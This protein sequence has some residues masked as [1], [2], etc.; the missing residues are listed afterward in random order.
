MAVQPGSFNILNHIRFS[1]GDLKSINLQYIRLGHLDDGT[2][3]LLTKCLT[4]QVIFFFKIFCKSFFR[5]P[6]NSFSYFFI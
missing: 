1:G 2:I 5:N 6:F 3:E 4:F